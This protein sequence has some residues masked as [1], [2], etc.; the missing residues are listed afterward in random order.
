MCNLVPPLDCAVVGVAYVPPA[1]SPYS[2]SWRSG[3]RRTPCPPPLR[4][5][6]FKT[7]AVCISH[8]CS[9]T[10]P[11]RVFQRLDIHVVHQMIIQH[12]IANLLGRAS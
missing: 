7:R 5:A 2:P 4:R 12:S 10:H 8:I 1:I 9:F 3:E 11:Q 6:A